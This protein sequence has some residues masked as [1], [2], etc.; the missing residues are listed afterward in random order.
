MFMK[1]SLYEQFYKQ[2]FGKREAEVTSEAYF[3]KIQ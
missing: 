3:K 1:D 2:L